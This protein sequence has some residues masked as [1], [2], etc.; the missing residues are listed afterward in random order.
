[1]PSMKMSLPPGVSRISPSPCWTSI[2]D[3]LSSASGRN[4]AFL[5]IRPSTIG[6]L[7]PF[8]RTRVSLAL[9]LRM[10][11]SSP[12]YSCHTTPSSRRRSMISSSRNGIAH[13]PHKGDSA[14]ADYAS[15]SQLQDNKRAPEWLPGPCIEHGWSGVLGLGVDRLLGS[16]LL[17]A[18]DGGA[19]PP[20]FRAGADIDLPRLHRLGDLADQ[21]DRQ[22]AVLQ[23]GAAHLDVVGQRETALERAIG[24]A[25]VD[26]VRALL[27]GLVILSPGNDQHVLLGGDV[28]LVGLEAGDR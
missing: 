5:E 6:P 10:S 22:Q 24:D 4:L 27:L 23:V 9:W 2:L 25:A 16:R 18:A 12:Q 11:T 3:S 1:P 15:R 13:L 14:C 21:F 17:F 8:T 7:R 26:E 19:F 28:D 20:R